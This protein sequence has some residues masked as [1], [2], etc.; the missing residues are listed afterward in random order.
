MLISYSLPSPAIIIQSHDLRCM[1]SVKHCMCQVMQ[2]L[3][4]QAWPL[5]NDPYHR[6][7]NRVRRISLLFFF[8]SWKYQSYNI[9]LFLCFK[10]DASTQV[11]IFTKVIK[12]TKKLVTYNMLHFITIMVILFIII[13]IL[14][15]KSFSIIANRLSDHRH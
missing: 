9:T 12:N 2:R 3:V 15:N 5:F 14:S 1:T 7:L 6:L 10:L 8:F 13:I 11:D 4:S